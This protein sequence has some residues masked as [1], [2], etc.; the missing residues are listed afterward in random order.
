MLAFFPHSYYAL[1]SKATARAPYLK[2]EKR[3]RRPPA[4]PALLSVL[5]SSLVGLLS[6]V[7]QLVVSLRLLLLQS[8]FLFLSVPHQLTLSSVYFP[9]SVHCWRSS[10]FLLSVG[11]TKIVPRRSSKT[12]FGFVCLR[13][14]ISKELMHFCWVVCLSSLSER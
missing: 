1:L 13:L 2:R 14:G 12:F 6:S 7:S 8:P 9:P 10:C 4:Q 3:D 5:F 11:S